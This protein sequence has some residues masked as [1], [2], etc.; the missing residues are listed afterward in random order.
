MEPL[1]GVHG[2]TA[3][4]DDVE[5]HPLDDVDVHDG[6]LPANRHHGG[7]VGRGGPVGAGAHH[8]HHLHHNPHNHLQH[9]HHLTVPPLPLP[10]GVA[11]RDHGRD[12][13]HGVTDVDTN[14]PVPTKRPWKVASQYDGR[15][16]V[17]GCDGA[18]KKKKVIHPLTGIATTSRRYSP[19]DYF[20]VMF[21]REQLDAMVTFTSNNLRKDKKKPTTAGELLKW[22]GV[23]ILFAFLEVDDRADGWDTGETNRHCKYLPCPQLG[24]TG[25]SRE[26]YEELHRHMVWSYQP[27]HRSPQMSPETYRNMLVQDFV[28]RFNAHRKSYFTPSSV[29]TV[30]QSTVPPQQVLETAMEQQLQQQQ[31]QDR[32]EMQNSA[33]GY[34]GIMLR[35]KLD[36]K[37][38]MAQEQQQDKSHEHDEATVQDDNG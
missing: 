21:P 32:C 28:D 35:L 6:K 2:A 31:V 9:Q 22:F 25:M 19:Y 20:M 4:V 10:P 29:I 34:S 26:R 1:V 5:I 11:S 15:E 8:Q 18:D 37:S 3:G 13:Y 12:W 16:F 36:F 7:G 14:G 23:T 17:P 38:A 27:V 24:R 30:D 33:C